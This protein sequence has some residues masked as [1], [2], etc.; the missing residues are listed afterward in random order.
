MKLSNEKVTEEVKVDSNDENSL[1]TDENT[2]GEHTE[3]AEEKTT[4]AI[5]NAEEK[6]V[7]PIVDSKNTFYDPDERYFLSPTEI[8]DELSNRQKV[9]MANYKKEKRLQLIMTIVIFALFLAA[10]VVMFIGKQNLTFL[11]YIFLGAAIVAFIINIVINSKFKK[12]TL[13]SID[14]Y[15]HNYFMILDSFIFADSSCQEV[16]IGPNANVED[17]EIIEAHYFDTI[18]SINS[19]NRVTAS[20]EGIQFIVNDVAV[21][22]P[23][24]KSSSKKDT[25]IGFYGT[26]YAFEYKTEDSFIILRKSDTDTCTAVPTYLDGYEEVTVEGLNEHFKVYATNQESIS[27]L[28]TDS[29][30]AALE[31]LVVDKNLLDYFISMNPNGIKIALNYSDDMMSV[32]L[33]TKFTQEVVNKHLDDKNAVLEI[34]SAIIGD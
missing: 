19:R 20:Y 5:D 15:V 34:V 27:K 31:K 16:K 3:A 17:S 2:E 23:S 11:M 1:E 24:T 21:R 10:L 7:N 33:E 22:I 26:Y 29:F 4:V 8:F 13:N 14:T 25:D 18:I 9:F 12:N 6:T 28:F 30:K 32:P